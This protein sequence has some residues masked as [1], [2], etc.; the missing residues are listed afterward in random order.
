MV[1]RG[2]LGL[3]VTNKNIQYAILDCLPFWHCKPYHLPDPS[4]TSAAHTNTLWEWLLMK[5]I[6]RSPV[7]DLG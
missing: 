4:V 6:D 5:I 2:N 7:L 3:K 1:C